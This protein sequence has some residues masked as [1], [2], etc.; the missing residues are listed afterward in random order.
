MSLKGSLFLLLIF[1]ISTVTFPWGLY[2]EQDSLLKVAVV[3][4][5]PSLSIQGSEVVYGLVESIVAVRTSATLYIRQEQAPRFLTFEHAKLPV[6]CDDLSLSQF[7]KDNERYDMVFSELRFRTSTSEMQRRV[8]PI[9]LLVSEY[10]ARRVSMSIHIAMI[11]RIHYAT[12]A[13]TSIADPEVCADEFIKETR[14]WEDPLTTKLFLKEE[15]R[16]Q[17][18]KIS[19]MHT[20]STILMPRPFSTLFLEKILKAPR[21]RDCGDASAVFD[22]RCVSCSE[23]SNCVKTC[24]IGIQLDLDRDVEL[25]VYVSAPGSSADEVFLGGYLDDVLQQ[26]LQA[27]WEVVAAT[28]SA[29]FFYLFIAELSRRS[30]N[31]SANV[32]FRIVLLERDEGLYETWDLLIG[33]YTA[34]RLLQNWN[35]DDRKHKSALSIKVKV[36][37]LQPNTNLVSSAVLASKHPNENWETSYNKKETE[38]WFDQLEGYYGLN[39]LFGR[40]EGGRVGSFNLPHNSPMY[41]RLI[42]IKHGGFSKRWHHAPLSMRVSPTCSDFRYWAHVLKSGDMFFHVNSP[43]EVYYINTNSHN[44]LPENMIDEC[45]DQAVSEALSFATQIPSKKLGLSGSNHRRVFLF[46]DNFTLYG[47]SALL[48]C[49]LE[50][51]F[52]GIRLHL[53]SPQ[54]MPV[55][56]EQIFTPQTMIFSTTSSAS[57]PGCFEL[58]VTL[59]QDPL[60]HDRLIWHKGYFFQ[61]GAMRHVSSII[62]LK[63]YI[64]SLV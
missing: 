53:L 64:R 61:P 24:H 51:V 19:T 50:M 60:L 2:K 41:R 62:E 25:S 9:P 33:M 1:L 34:G 16:A 58:A 44:R 13:K 12:C 54:A 56:W 28:A 8:I 7:L 23:N 26:D 47:I 11:D 5:S 14:V 3:L 6:V 30:S 63:A 55:E 21:L 27:D 57:N 10:L 35:V 17:A 49:L 29:D 15:D 22:Q 36:L 4:E 45:V 42:H 39:M 18:M 43:M 52:A 37:S 48:E 32:S 40:T 59:A 38:V 20:A 46:V 31:L